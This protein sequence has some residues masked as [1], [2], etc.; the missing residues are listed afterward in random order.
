ML[1]ITD[2][3]MPD[4]AT[5]ATTELPRSPDEAVTTVVLVIDTSQVTL[6]VDV[7]V[8]VLEAAAAVVGLLVGNFLKMSSLAFHP[9]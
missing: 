7:T 2:G 6:V 9:S 1:V 8:L 4:S 3:L 5:V